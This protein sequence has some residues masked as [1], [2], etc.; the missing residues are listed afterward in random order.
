VDPDDVDAA[1]SFLAFSCVGGAA[2][3]AIRGHTNR[4]ILLDLEG[5]T[6]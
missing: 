1:L 3:A 5:S 2:V 4:R 6:R